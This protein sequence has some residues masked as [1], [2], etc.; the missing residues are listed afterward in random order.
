MPNSNISDDKIKDLNPKEPH[1]YLKLAV[2]FT[3]RFAGATLGGVIGGVLEQAIEGFMEADD[4]ITSPF[5]ESRG[6]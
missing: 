6:G 5:S 2:N 3:A 4:S 1:P